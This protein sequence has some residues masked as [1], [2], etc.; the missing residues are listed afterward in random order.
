MDRVVGAKTHRL[1]GRRGEGVVRTELAAH[2]KEKPVLDEAPALELARLALAIENHYGAPQ[3]IEWALDKAGQ[4]LILQCRPL[5]QCPETTILE[6]AGPDPGI[7]PLLAGGI[8]ASPG[9]GA[10]PVCRVTK[11]ADMLSFPRG[12]VLVTAQALPEWAPLLSRAAAV[13]TEQGSPAG[14]LA[15]VAREFGRPALFNLTGAL[16]QLAPNQWVTV[17]AGSG[18]VYPG[19]VEALLKKK[20]AP[21]SPMAGSPIHDLLH[22]ISRLCGAA[23]P[24]RPGLARIHPGKLPNPSR[25]HPAGPREIGP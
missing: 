12:A 10:G 3:D 7:P 23:Q 15:S 19:R 1:D 25:H 14:H 21:V 16:D 5:Q 18:A 2:L 17:D 13:V 8:T 22:G 9:S 20:P 11:R 4:W 6:P 24:A